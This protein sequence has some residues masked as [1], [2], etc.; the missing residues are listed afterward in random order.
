MREA[1]LPLLEEV[2]AHSNTQ[3]ED[4]EVRGHTDDRL[5]VEGRLQIVNRYTM[6]V[7]WEQPLLTRRFSRTRLMLDF[8]DRYWWH[9]RLSYYLLPFK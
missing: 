1:F 9:Q 8:L 2:K 3:G 4:V 7:P 6:Y 5:V